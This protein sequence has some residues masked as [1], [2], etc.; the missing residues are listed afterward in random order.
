M[1]V[2]YDADG[3]RSVQAEVEVPGTPEQVWQA[4]AT[5]P[6]ISS[7]FVPSEVDERVG[8][9]AVSNFG[10]G[11]ESVGTITAWE[12]P[13]RFIVDTPAYGE[14]EP[15]LPP[16]G[17]S[18]RGTAVR[19]SYASSTAGSPRAMPGTTS[20]SAIRMAGRPSSASSASMSPA[21]TGV[22]SCLSRRWASRPNRR[23]RPGRPL[24]RRSASKTP[25]SATAFTP[26]PARRGL[27]GRSSG[28]VNPRRRKIC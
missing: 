5:G 11:M 19:A 6:G 4:I 18:K 26:A 3:R 22:R 24:P 10:P 7:W 25:P 13:R 23:N 9:K 14:E 1:S 28:P 27:P 12:P 21:S 15:A 8:G 2:Q 17:R 20:S 16:N